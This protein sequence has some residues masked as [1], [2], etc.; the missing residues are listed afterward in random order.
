MSELHL[1][2]ALDVLDGR[3]EPTFSVEVLKRAITV[4]VNLPEIAKCACGYKG[5][6]FVWHS[7]LA[8]VECLKGGCWCGP[9]RHTERGAINAWNRVMEAGK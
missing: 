4:L 3:R 9:N 1:K 8:R 2:E 7:G 5:D 6:I